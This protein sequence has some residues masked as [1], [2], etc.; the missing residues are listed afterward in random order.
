MFNCT[1]SRIVTSY[2]GL[3][4][5]PLALAGFVASL[6]EFG[7]VTRCSEGSRHLSLRLNNHF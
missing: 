3:P 5:K 1:E 4:G 7:P 2:S 6:E